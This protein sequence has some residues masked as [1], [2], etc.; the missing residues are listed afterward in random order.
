MQQ[1]GTADRCPSTRKQAQSIASDAPTQEEHVNSQYKIFP[2][3]VQAQQKSRV[4]IRVQCGLDHPV[5]IGFAA[6]DDERP[7]KMSTVTVL[8][9]VQG[10]HQ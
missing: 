1:T 5:C 8:L 2:M 10:S 6:R 4:P 3:Q 7:Y 9:K